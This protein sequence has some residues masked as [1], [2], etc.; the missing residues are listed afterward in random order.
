MEPRGASLLPQA[1][2]DPGQARSQGNQEPAAPEPARPEPAGVQPARPDLA[3][4][5]LAGLELDA[6]DLPAR[7]RGVIGLLE[8][9]CTVCMLCARE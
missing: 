3:G 4:R 8:E 2:G 5:E 6:G 1:Q 9:N 7:S